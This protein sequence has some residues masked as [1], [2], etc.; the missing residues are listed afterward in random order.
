MQRLEGV[1]DNMEG[2]GQLAVRTL[3]LKRPAGTVRFVG[4]GHLR[5]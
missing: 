1:L 2:Y 3:S 4:H 5:R